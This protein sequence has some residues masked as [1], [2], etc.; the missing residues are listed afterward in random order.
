VATRLGY[1]YFPGRYSRLL[2]DLNRSEHHPR[3]VP[4]RAFAV[5][6]PGNEDLSTDEINLR[7]ERYWRPH[8]EAVERA[9]RLRTRRRRACLHVGLHSFTPVLGGRR[10]YCDV[11]LLFDPARA[12]EAATARALRKSLQSSG[13]SIR[14]NYPY[15]GTSDGLTTAMRKRLPPSCYAGME[16]ELNQRLLTDARA[17][18]RVAEMLTAALSALVARGKNA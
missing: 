1:P 15:R 9:L 18:A 12:L 10:R 4:A 11:G 13:L 3:L 5:V 8:W 14:F 17:R 7:V 2:I 6:V 16:I